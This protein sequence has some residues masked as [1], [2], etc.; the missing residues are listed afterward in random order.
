MLDYRS[1][2][3][4]LWQQRKQRSDHLCGQ[5][6]PYTRIGLAVGLELLVLLALAY[7]WWSALQST[8]LVGLGHVDVCPCRWSRNHD[9]TGRDAKATPVHIQ[10]D[11][12]PALSLGCERR[13]V[14]GLLKLGLLRGERTGTGFDITEASILAFKKMYVSVGSFARELNSWCMVENFTIR[15]KTQ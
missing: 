7:R 9:A 6:R 1:P 3:Y 4:G 11:P 2:G 8:S 15:C 5:S 13:F 12:L 10:T 14:P